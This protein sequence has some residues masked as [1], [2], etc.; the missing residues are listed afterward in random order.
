MLKGSRQ[1]P[2]ERLATGFESIGSGLGREITDDYFGFTLQTVSHRFTEALEILFDMLFHPELAPAEVL[3]ERTIQLAAIRR[4]RDESMPLAFSLFRQVA[5]PDTNYSLPI[6]GS[7]RS[8]GG[9]QPRQVRD[10][11]S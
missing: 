5:F 7:S 2:G 3:K 11:I 9:L 6:V 10:W 4:L 1:W 8:A